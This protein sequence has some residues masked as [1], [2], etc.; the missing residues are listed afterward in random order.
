[1]T[2]TRAVGDLLR[3]WRERRRLSQLELACLADVSTR[4]VSFLETGRS[5]PSREMLLHLAE[6]LEIPLRSRNGLLLAAGLAPEYPERALDDAA[7]A[8]VRKAID[9]VLA[10]HEPYPALAIDRHWTMATANSGVGPL[11]AGVDPELLRPPVNVLRLSL[12]PGGLAPRIDNLA[13][14]RAHLLARLRHQIEATADF[15]LAELLAELEQLPHGEAPARH[16]SYGGVIVQLRLRRSTAR[17]PFVSTTTI[18]GTPLD[19]TLAELAIESFFPADRTT[20]EALQ[21]A[22]A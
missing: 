16:E 10:G 17:S 21:R 20:A 6:R 18:L 15:T 5:R 19:I 9:L 13:E 2:G 8:D 22:S 7:M 12:H 3:S 14:W 1:M 11:L 4:Q